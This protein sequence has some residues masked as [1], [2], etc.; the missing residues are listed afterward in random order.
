M[1]EC[2][3]CN[4]VFNSERAANQH[5]DTKNHWAERFYCETCNKEFFSQGASEQH[6]NATSHWRPRVPCETCDEMFYTPDA[7]NQHMRDQGHWATRFYCDT[8]DKEFFSQHAVEQHMSSVS[9]WKFSMI[10]RAEKLDFG[11]L[12]YNDI[13]KRFDDGWR[14][15]GKSAYVQHIYINMDYVARA[16]VPGLQYLFHG[17]QR[18]CHVGDP[19]FP[20]KHCNNGECH[21]CGIMRG[22]FKLEYASG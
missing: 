3:T 16:Q 4:R 17:T 10:S 2:E 6:M 19:N 11:C 15:T 13:K 8:C 20:L 1:F 18:A 14:H 22:G 12:D 5:M 21:V 7:A 9:H